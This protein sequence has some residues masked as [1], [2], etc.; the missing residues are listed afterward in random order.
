LA[1][2]SPTDASSSISFFGDRIVS[3]LGELP[4]L[5]GL[6]P[7]IVSPVHVVQ[8]NEPRAVTANARPRAVCVRS[9]YQTGLVQRG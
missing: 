2:S 4:I 6:V 5:G 1:T 9:M 3:L 8:S 7:A